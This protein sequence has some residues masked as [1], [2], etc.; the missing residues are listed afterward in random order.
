MNIHKDSMSMTG[1]TTAALCILS[2]VGWMLIGEMLV[3]GKKSVKECI[4]GEII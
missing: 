3:T 4:L 2:Q 1:A